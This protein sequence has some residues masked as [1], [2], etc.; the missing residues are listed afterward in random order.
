LAPNPLFLKPQQ[1][2]SYPG[3]GSPR[4]LQLAFRFNF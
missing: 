3:I 1:A 4:Q 2:L